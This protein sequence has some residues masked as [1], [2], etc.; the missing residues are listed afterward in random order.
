MS[1]RLS[2]PPTPMPVTSRLGFPLKIVEMVTDDEIE[3]QANSEELDEVAVM[4][5]SSASGDQESTLTAATPPRGDNYDMNAEDDTENEKI[6]EIEL[7]VNIITAPPCSDSFGAH[8]M[9]SN[10]NVNPAE[11]VSM[12]S[13]NIPLPSSKN[14]CETSPEQTISGPRFMSKL[15]TP[16]PSEISATTP[17]TPTWRSSAPRIP[18]SSVSTSHRRSLL[19]PMGSRIPRYRHS[20]PDRNIADSVLQPPSLRFVTSRSYSSYPSRVMTPP[21]ISATGF[22]DADDEKEP[23]QDEAIDGDQ[24]HKEDTP[25]PDTS[26]Y[27]K[28]GH[29][30]LRREA[31]LE[32]LRSPRSARIAPY[33][34]PRR[35]LKS[36]TDIVRSPCS[37]ILRHG[38]MKLAMYLRSSAR[39]PPLPG[40]DRV[41]GAYD[42][43]KYRKR[44]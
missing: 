38:S 35:L 20:D 24:L 10:A 5:D 43:D 15:R 42:V 28:Q 23:V 6:K 4:P 18:W 22:P 13:R 29:L 16:A 40:F 1:R 19:T 9:P 27:Q 33:Y 25:H 17:T 39:P 44:E 2:R 12:I 34:V 36:P 32:P 26:D 37:E 14:E 7:A 41:A 21:S 31:L 30:S 8:Q 11:E 3:P